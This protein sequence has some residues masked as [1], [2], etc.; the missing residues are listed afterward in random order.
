MRSALLSFLALGS[1]LLTLATLLGGEGWDLLFGVLAIAFPVALCALGAMHGER[2]SPGIAAV[3]L[4]LLA[5][6]EGSFLGMLALRGQVLDGPR[7]AGMPLA[8][9]LL[10]AG[11]WL[12]PLLLVSFGYA[13]T[14]RW[15]PDPETEGLEGA[16]EPGGAK[17]V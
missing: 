16:A 8:V 7:L 12:L 17:P 13:V 4:A 6:L 10:L 11:M 9:V 14:F 15:E 2:L 1:L 3:L 5:L